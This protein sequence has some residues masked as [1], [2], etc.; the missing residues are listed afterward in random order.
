MKDFQVID[1]RR[2]PLKVETHNTDM[3]PYYRWEHR[4][5]LGKYMQGSFR[6]FMVFID[7]ITTKLYI[8][9]IN[10]GNTLQVIEDDELFEALSVFA[11]E[12]G[13]VKIL[14]PLLK[15]KLERFV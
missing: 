11:D 3:L 5:T 13:Y 10:T 4:V 8:E 12:G 9:E 1:E 14:A 15:P 6:T 7:N 2:Y